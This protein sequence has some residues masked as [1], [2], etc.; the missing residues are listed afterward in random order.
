MKTPPSKNAEYTILSSK[1]TPNAPTIIISDN[2]EKQ[3]IWVVTAIDMN[4]L[5]FNC[6]AW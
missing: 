1:I 6:L 2:T 3:I 4:Y 5:E